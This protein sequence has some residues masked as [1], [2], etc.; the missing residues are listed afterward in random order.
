[1]CYVSSNA[2]MAVNDK[3]KKVLNKAITALMYRQH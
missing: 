3:S 1:M 2:W